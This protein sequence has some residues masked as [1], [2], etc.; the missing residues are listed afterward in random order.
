MTDASVGVKNPPTIPPTI[1]AGVISAKIAPRNAEK[2]S[3][4]EARWATG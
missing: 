2:N 3:L 1:M 4:A